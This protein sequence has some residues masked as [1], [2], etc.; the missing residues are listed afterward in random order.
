MVGPR[1]NAARRQSRAARTARSAGLRRLLLAKAAHISRRYRSQPHVRTRHRFDMPVPRMG[2]AAS[3]VS[4]RRKRA[5]NVS[6]GA[7][8][9]ATSPLLYGHI[10]TAL[11]RS[12]RPPTRRAA[13]TTRPAHISHS[14]ESLDCIVSA[15]RHARLRV[16][17]RSRICAFPVFLRAVSTGRHRIG[18][19]RR[20]INFACNETFCRTA[21]SIWGMQMSRVTASPKARREQRGAMVQAL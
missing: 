16:T 21:A 19:A 11:R 2:I 9:R 7:Q 3:V 10:G 6:P 8:D 5:P 12:R 1:A 17:Q 18:C 4:A 20:I 15:R 14:D 13:R